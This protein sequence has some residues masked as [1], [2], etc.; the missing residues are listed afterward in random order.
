MITIELQ[1]SLN[2]KNIQ[3]IYG[4]T[5][6]G[7]NSIEICFQ[8]GFDGPYLQ[9]VHCFPYSE[10]RIEFRKEKQS[11]NNVFYKEIRTNFFEVLTYVCMPSLTQK[12]KARDF[13][14]DSE[15]SSCGLKVGAKCKSGEC[16]DPEILASKYGTLPVMKHKILQFSRG[17]CSVARKYF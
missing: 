9:A 5:F 1:F 16:W 13:N 12:Q 10:F 11:W 2:S 6:C 14:T 4:C 3:Y 8:G 15:S 17:H 7:P